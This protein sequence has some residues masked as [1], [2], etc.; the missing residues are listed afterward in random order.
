MELGGG[1]E[2]SPNSKDCG[3][4]GLGGRAAGVGGKKESAGA[5]AV[6]APVLFPPPL[7]ASFSAPLPTK[8]TRTGALKVFSQRKMAT[9]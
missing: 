8:H 5:G 2:T 4:R 6:G 9:D 7:R 3:R 1:L